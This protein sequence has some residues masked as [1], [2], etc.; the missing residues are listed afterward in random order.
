MVFFFFLF[1]LSSNSLWSHTCSA[2]RLLHQET[3]V[4]LKGLF[5]YLRTCRKSDHTPTKDKEN[6]EL[7]VVGKQRGEKG[8]MAG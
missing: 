2:T 6:I 3:V 8:N 5:L 1:F 4:M 7:Q